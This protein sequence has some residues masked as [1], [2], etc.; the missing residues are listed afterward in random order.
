MLGPSYSTQPRKVRSCAGVVYA[1]SASGA[2]RN[3][4]LLS[5]SCQKNSTGMSMRRAAWREARL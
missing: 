4:R 3:L 2:L 5:P 1:L